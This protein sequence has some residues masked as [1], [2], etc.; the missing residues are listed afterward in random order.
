M[1]TLCLDYRPEILEILSAI[2]EAAGCEVL[3][4]TD[5][6]EAWALLH[7]V[8]VDLFTQDLTLFDIDGHEFLRMLRADIQLKSIPVLIV[9]ARVDKQEIL[10]AYKEGADGYVTKPFPLQYIL[11]MINVIV[12][13]CQMSPL[14]VSEMRP[15]EPRIE[16]AI[17]GLKDRHASVRLAAVNSLRRIKDT[18][19]VRPIISLLRDR[20]IE[21]RWAAIHTLGLLNDPRAVQPLVALLSDANVL[22]RWAAA[23]ALGRLGAKEALKPFVA[24]LADENSLVRMMAALGLGYLKEPSVVPALRMRLTD[25]D[26]M[27]ARAARRA[28]DDIN[29]EEDLRKRGPGQRKREKKQGELPGASTDVWFWRIFFLVIAGLIGLTIY[30]HWTK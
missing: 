13:A 12:P 24:A 1:R 21:V 25:T 29:A 22:N 14:S 27:V 2:L 7:S 20:E 26:P 30:E 4:T 3:A 16:T 15:D 9:S 10:A 8:P 6:Y 18:R 17:Q 5:T 11:N 19:A 23:L 28:L